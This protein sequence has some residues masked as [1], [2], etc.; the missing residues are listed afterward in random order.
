MKPPQIHF[1][2]LR[3]LAATLF[4]QANME[5]VFTGRLLMLEA[6]VSSVKLRIQ[7]V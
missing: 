7:V 5:E 3:V 4:Q 2:V 1:M 6:K